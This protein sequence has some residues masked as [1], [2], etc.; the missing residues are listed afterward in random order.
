MANKSELVEDCVELL[1]APAKRGEGGRT[2]AH[3]VKL[4]SV[5]ELIRMAL[6]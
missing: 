4:V 2:C 6:R 1:P 3:Q 5:R